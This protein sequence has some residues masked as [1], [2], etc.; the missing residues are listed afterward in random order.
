MPTSTEQIAE[1]I[2]SNTELKSYFEGVRGDIDRKVADAD[3]R[4][5]GFIAGAVHQFPAFNLFANSL[6]TKVDSSG[7]PSGLYIY[8]NGC[9]LKSSV[10]SLEDG[11]WWANTNRVWRL[12]IERTKDGAYCGFSTNRLTR[13]PHTAGSGVI[14]TRGFKYR[15]L[16]N[17]RDKPLR[18]SWEA[19][20]R[21]IDSKPDGVWKNETQTV[22]H[23][24][25]F[26]SLFSFQSGDRV[27]GDRIILE[28]RDIFV[29]IGAYDR[30][31][32]SIPEML[33][34]TLFYQEV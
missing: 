34:M 23:R 5:D 1:L 30:Y 2:R 28:L 25:Q 32:P 19:G 12:E 3:K 17:N 10:H 6:L 16:Q 14:T 18:I 13:F 8:N 22:N 24:S 4:V 33:D 29:C 26:T 11:G 21:I 27:A 20:A 31:V 7:F 15:V 9:A